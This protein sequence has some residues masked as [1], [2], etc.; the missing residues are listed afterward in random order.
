MADEVLGLPPDGAGQQLDMEELTVSGETVLRQRA[1]I[2]GKA[3]AE[4]ADVKNAEPASGAYGV[5]VREA[6][7]GQAP[8]AASIP[9][10]LASNQT[11]I[12]ITDNGGSLTV[13]GT[14]G[15]SGTV[16][17]DS[18]LPAAAALADGAANPT[19]PAVDAKL[20]IFNGSTWDRARGDTSNGVDVDVTRLPASALAAGNLVQADYD[21]GAGTQ[22]VPLVGIGLPASGGAV[23]GGTSTNPVRTDPTGSTTQPI[24]ASSLPLP[25]GAATA[26]KQDQVIASLDLLDDAVHAPNGALS[27]VLAIGGQFDDASSTAATEDA[28]SPV[29]ITQQR[30]QHVNLRSGA[31]EIGTSGNPLRTDP[32][33][34]TT[35]PVNPTGETAGVGV[36]AI[37]DAEAAAGNGSVIAILKR[38]RTLLASVATDTVLQA[39]R[40]RLPSALVSNR[41]DV[42]VGAGTVAVTQGTASSLNAQAVG[43]VA[44]DAADS[45]NPIKVGG[46]AVD[47]GSNPTAVAAGDRI[48]F[49]GNRHGIPFVE[50]AHP[51]TQTAEITVVDADEGEIDTPIVSVSSGTRIRVTGVAITL[52]AATAA[53]V[54]CRIGFGST[55]LPAASNTPVAGIVASHPGIAPGSGLVKTGM[56]SKGGDGEDLRITCGD[57]GSGGSL[58]AVVEYHTVPA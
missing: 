13:D 25:A 22:Q 58:V 18:E 33:G 20:A 14:V 53:P 1:Q 3:A 17:V 56:K 16:P 48:D 28:V 4:I 35:Q 31:S 40:D 36:G 29:R 21:N 55:T 32:T 57:V 52:S 34:T 50:E 41:L 46:R 39:V 42:N 11:A 45:G 54:P 38:L 15:V 26:A 5:V 47:Y 9:V 27:K 10:A 49:L 12:P 6:A 2:S 23:P 8:M 30:A 37:A 24:S 19:A 44:H 51:N 43:N 7:R